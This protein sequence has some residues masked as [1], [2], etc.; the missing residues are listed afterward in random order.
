[1]STNQPSKSNTDDIIVS[2]R[3]SGI[4]LFHDQHKEAYI[5]IDGTSKNVLAIQSKEF[6][7]WVGQYAYNSLARTLNI[8]AIE[9]IVTTLSGI[10][11]FDGVM[12]ELNVRCVSKNSLIWY[13]L[14][15]SAVAVG[16]GTWSVFDDPGIMFR[17]FQ[18]QKAQVRPIESENVDL[19]RDYINIEDDNDWL[20][21][22]VALIAAFIPGFPHP[23]L[24]LHGPQGSGKTTPLEMLKEIIDPSLLRGLP[25]PKNQ[26]EFVHIATKHYFFFYDNLSFM[27]TWLSDALARACTGD[28]FSKRAL[29]TNDDDV[30][31]TF[32]RSIAIN[33]IP[34]VV[35]KSDLLDRAIP[36]CLSRISDSQRKPYSDLCVCFFIVILRGRALR[37]I[38]I[39][40]PCAC[41]SGCS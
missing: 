24:I 6:K 37:S 4:K 19:L 38:S 40:I 41:K 39:S 35:T 23:L 10:A 8:R 1:M 9:K 7:Q 16:P 13:D 31:Y 18:H 15:S 20:L 36:I 26:E 34:Q 12:I 32:Q 11:L 21:F 5:A 33:G 14:G 29:Y 2:I 3:E 22:V 17:R 27:P 25:P 30:I 28:G